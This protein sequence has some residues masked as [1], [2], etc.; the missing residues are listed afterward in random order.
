MSSGWVDT[1]RHFEKAGGHYSWWSQRI[2]LRERNVGWR[3]DCHWLDRSLLPRLRR[4]AIHADVLGSDHC[5][6]SIDL[7]G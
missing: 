6:V 7:A 2:G 1:F 4:A 3:I 5:P